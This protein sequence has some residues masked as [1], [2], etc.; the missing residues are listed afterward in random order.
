ME[1]AAVLWE[2]AKRFWKVGFTKNIILSLLVIIGI[3]FLVIAGY[4]DESPKTSD[5]GTIVADNEGFPLGEHDYG[6]VKSIEA[7]FQDIY[8]EAAETNILS[9]LEILR[10]IVD[11]LGENGYSAVDSENQI[12]MVCPEQIRQ[13]CGQVEAQKEAKVT[14]VV[15]VS[16][17]SFVKYEFMTKD[18]NVEVQ[19]SHCLYKGGCWETV[20]VKNYQAYT[21]VCSKGGYLFFEEYHMPGFDGPSGNTAVR[22]EPLDETCRELNRKYLKTIGYRLNNL[23]TSDW[24]EDEYQEL[25]FYD[26]FEVMHQMKNNEYPESFLNEGE[27][28]E[29]PKTEFED[30]FQTFFRIDGQT[31]QKYTTYHESTETYQYRTRGMYD[32]APTP[33]IPYPEV[34][35]CEENQDGTIKLTVNAV[36]PDENLEKAFCHEVIIRPLEDG[37]FQYVSN[38]VIPSEDNVEITWYT[39]RLSDDEWQEYYGGVVLTAEEE[40]CLQDEAMSAAEQCMEFYKDFKVGYYGTDYSRIE[41]F[42]YEHRKNV[43]KYL[44]EQGLVSV[45]DDINMENYQKVEEFYSAYSSGND[46]MVTVFNVYK[47]GNIGALTFIH[48]NGK[49]QT[50]YVSIDWREGGIPEINYFGINELEEI[51][52]T[53][54]GYF[55]YTYAE[56]IVH[57]SLREYFRVKPLSDECREMTKKYIYGLS[58]VNYNMLVTNWDES[59]VEEILMP[60]MFEDIYRIYTGEEIKTEKGQI[61]GETYER[62]MTTCFPVSAEQVRKHCGYNADTD[63]YEYEMIFPRQFPPFGEVVDYIWNEDGT[64]T[65]YVDGVW[66]DYNSDYAFTNRIMVQPFDDGTFRYLSNS[67]EQKELEPPRIEK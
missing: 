47:D 34:I 3:I 40:Q 20:S 17:I 61:E 27:S 56:T 37:G 49:I 50:Y 23:F 7:I 55:I 5:I 1:G 62:I 53:E 66:A 52:L 59:N 13:F 48:R 46:V 15:V 11:S 33:E 26:L 54:K 38:H 29:I 36:W 22:I 39:E 63:S 44:G 8:S 67:I 35:S 10:R 43:V 24:S 64:I 65:L 58:Y 51:K 25:N 6:D 12:N 21:W 41:D 16:S 30:A 60:C 31:L 4:S 19:R 42:S 14:L 57:G 2:K 18:G 45:S 28:Y 9:S 32:F